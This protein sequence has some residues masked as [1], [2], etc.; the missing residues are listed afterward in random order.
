MKHAL[1]IQEK[2]TGSRLV[3]PQIDTFRLDT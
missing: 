1:K 3:V 2:L